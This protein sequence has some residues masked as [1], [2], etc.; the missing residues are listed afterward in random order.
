MQIKQKMQNIFSEE[1]FLNF[2]SGDRWVHGILCLKRAHEDCDAGDLHIK[3]F[4]Y[5]LCSP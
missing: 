3:Q 5:D 2:A 4:M 1:T